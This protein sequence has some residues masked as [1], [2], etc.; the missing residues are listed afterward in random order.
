M[1][2][3]TGSAYVT[4]FGLALK[5][6]EA[7][8]GMSAKADLD[9]Q[10]AE[11]FQIILAGQR[12]ALEE[13]VKQRALLE[14]VSELEEKLAAFEAWSAEKPRY[15]L[16]EPWGGGLVRALKQSASGGEPAHWICA[17]CYENRKKGFLVDVLVQPKSGHRQVGVECGLCKVQT[18]SQMAGGTIER[19]YAEDMA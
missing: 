9:K 17:S 12:S 11:L 19:K 6:L 7:M 14:T 16:A 8:K 5:G 1:V 3:P 2:D 4:A 18:L 15:A 13:S 10:A